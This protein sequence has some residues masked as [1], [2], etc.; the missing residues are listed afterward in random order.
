MW[1]EILVFFNTPV[2]RY[3]WDEEEMVDPSPRIPMIWSIPIILGGSVLVV[4]LVIL[5]FAFVIK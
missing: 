2:K 3:Y 4:F 1:K 5:I